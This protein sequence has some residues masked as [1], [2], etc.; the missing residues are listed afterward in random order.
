MDRGGPAGPSSY[1][2]L[3]ERTL[4]LLPLGEECCDEE[5]VVMID[6]DGNDGGLTTGF[7]SYRVTTMSTLKRYTARQGPAYRAPKQ[8]ADKKSPG[9]SMPSRH[10]QLPA[11]AGSRGPAFRCFGGSATSCGSGNG[12]GTSGQARPPTPSHRSYARQAVT[13]VSTSLARANAPDSSGIIIPQLP[14]AKRLESNF[15]SS[16]SEIEQQR[17]ALE[18]FLAKARSACGAELS[19]SAG[20]LPS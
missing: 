17:S 8:N 6:L 10:G 7:V 14:E 12:S 3:G 9:M 1:E 5:L 18:A 16:E 15:V 2:S 13:R 19:A 20:A 4:S 11:P